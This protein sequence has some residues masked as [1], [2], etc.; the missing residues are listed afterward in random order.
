ASIRAKDELH[1]WIYAILAGVLSGVAV[2]T[3]FTGLIAGA[4]VLLVFVWQMLKSSLPL[5]KGELEGVRRA[6]TSPNP[7]FVRRGKRFGWLL[8]ILVVFFVAVLVYLAGW[9][10]H[11]SLLTEPG[12]GDAWGIPTGYFWEDLFV[13]HKQMVSANY[14]LTAAHPYGS[15]WWTWPFMVRSVFYWQGVDNEFIYFLGNPIVWWGSFLL[16]I[17]GIL[18]LCIRGKYTLFSSGAWICILGYCVAYIPLMRV[19]R[20]LFLYHY[21]TPLIFSLVFGIWWVDKIFPKNKILF[22]G[23][24][25]ICILVG[26]IFISPLTYG[27]HL[28]DFWYKGLF[29]FSSW[30]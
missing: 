24:A 30:R 28:S 2:G 25:C 23:I 21:L 15:S 18:S 14:N 8:K 12:S 22:S 1:V 9:M 29:L 11:F 19:P 20:V 4:L 10:V 5:T 7:S 27:T 3:K 26:F 17:F 13:T 6:Q 16:F